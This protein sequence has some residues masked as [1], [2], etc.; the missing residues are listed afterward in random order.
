MSLLATSENVNN[1][2]A[3]ESLFGGREAAGGKSKANTHHNK[4]YELA[5][6]LNIAIRKTYECF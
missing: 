6:N 1:D 3:G 5:E 2:N 4:V